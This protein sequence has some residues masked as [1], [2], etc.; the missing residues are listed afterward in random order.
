MRREGD[1]MPWQG[2]GEA[3]QLWIDLDFLKV[4]SPLNFKAAGGVGPVGNLDSH[5]SS[6]RGLA[7]RLGPAMVPHS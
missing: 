6:A 4:P 5:A 2:F 3:L 1:Q 7:P